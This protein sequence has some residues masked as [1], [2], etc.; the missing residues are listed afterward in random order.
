[1]SLMRIVPKRVRDFF[2]AWR[3]FLWARAFL[4]GKDAAARNPAA[5]PADPSNPLRAYVR[6]L[7]SGPGVW[8]W[9][10][11]LDIYHRHFERFRGRE[12]HVVEIGVFSGGSLGLW[13]DYFGPRCHVYGVDID[14]ACKAYEGGAVRIFIGDQGDRDFWRRFKAAVPRVDIVIDDGAHLAPRQIVTLEELL[15]H[16]APGGVFLCEDVH[17]IFNGFA[18]YVNGLANELNAA[19]W[20]RQGGA[21]DQNEPVADVTRFQAM[22]GAIHLYPW[23]VVIEKPENPPDAF[24]APRFGSEWR[25]NAPSL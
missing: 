4:R 17:G 20:R 13:R 12:V 11:Y 19:K 18:L 2:R 8:K 22:A 6:A 24:I 7:R 10:H 3:M 23:V 25:P 9:D 16:L 21:A 5:A 15:P 1:V 14:P